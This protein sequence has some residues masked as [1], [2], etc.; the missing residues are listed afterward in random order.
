MK[1]IS[2]LNSDLYVSN[3]KFNSQN[4]VIS[5]FAEKF[6]SHY[7]NKISKEKIQNAIEERQKIGSTV[8]ESGMAVPHGR[9]DEFDDI[10]IGVCI[11]SVPVKVDGIDIKIFVIIISPQKSSTLYLQTL[12]AFAKIAADIGF[13]NKL[14]K[15]S[16]SK[17]L[18][19]QLEEIK[20]KKDLTVEDIMSASV[21]SVS[22]EMTLKQLADKFYEDKIGYAPVIDE[23][24]SLIGEVTM[25]ELLKTAIPD[26]AEKVGNLNFLSSFEPLE[27]LL[28][29]ENIIKVKEIMKNPEQT[30]ERSSSIVEASFKISHG[31][32][33]HIPV[34]ENGKIIGIISF[35]DILRKVIRR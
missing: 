26:Y 4:D 22:P 10:L 16:D 35:T 32:R 8:F 25:K 19:K 27:Y 20:I 31:N 30:L 13:M 23:N 14:S 6:S 12:A 34:V 3:L 7:K 33:R 5:F 2:M 1:L 15:C 29:N 28:K 9:I 21:I 11:P 17:E 24:G 18:F